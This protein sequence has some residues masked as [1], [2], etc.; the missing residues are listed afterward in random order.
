MSLVAIR[1]MFEL[2]FF[3][4]GKLQ[5]LAERVREN[6]AV[7]AVFLSTYQLRMNQRFELEVSN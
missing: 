7:S 2:Q 3:K 5:E 1:R 4:W 6:A